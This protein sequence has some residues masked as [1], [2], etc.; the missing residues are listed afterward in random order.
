[1]MVGDLQRIVEYPER[2]FAVPQAVPVAVGAAAERLRA[3]GFVSRALPPSGR[4]PR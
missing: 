3:A 4:R 1:M 2:G